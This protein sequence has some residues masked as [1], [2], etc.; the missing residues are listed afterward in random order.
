[1]T[2]DIYAWLKARGADLSNEPLLCS[3]ACTRRC[4]I[5]GFTVSEKAGASAL[6]Y[7]KDGVIARVNE[8]IDVIGAKLP[9]DLT[10]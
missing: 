6:A 2:Y 4:E 7:I 10:R 1:V 9:S 3:L 5:C 8:G